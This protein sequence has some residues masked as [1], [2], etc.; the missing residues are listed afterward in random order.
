MGNSC[1]LC[2]ASAIAA[3]ARLVGLTEFSDYIVYV[4]ESGD[5][6]LSSIDPDFPVF[7]L[8][9][10]IFEKAAY[11]DSIV[12]VVQ[13]FKFKHWGHDCAVLHENEIRKEKGDFAFLRG[14]RAIRDA[15][16]EGLSNLIQETELS[17]VATAIDKVRLKDRYPDPWSPYEIAL[18][19]CLERLL[20]FLRSNGQEGKR[21]HVV[22]ECRGKQEDRDLELEFRRVVSGQSQWGWVHRNFSSIEFEPRFA[23][24]QINSTGLQIADLFARPIALK[25]IR[26]LQSNRAYDIIQGK[27]H[28]LKVFP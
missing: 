14:D 18:H 23:R 21:I 27:M 20:S 13:K 1:S 7:C 12:P 26:P 16:H 17:V 4:D 9:F 28:D 11:S 5:H 22:F 15:F 8:A 2:D 3:V 6:S 24:K 19:L 25:A 10:C